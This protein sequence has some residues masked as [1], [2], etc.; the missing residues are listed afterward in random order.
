[1]SDVRRIIGG[2]DIIVSPHAACDLYFDDEY[3]DQIGAPTG[4]LSQYEICKVLSL[5]K[6]RPLYLSWEILDKCNFACPFCYIVGHSNNKIVRFSQIQPTLKRLI[7]K[8]LLFCTLTGGEATIHPDFEEIYTFLKMSGVV[9]EVYSN[10]HRISE[11]LISLFVK[12]PP[13]RLEIS[14]YGL[15]D[16]QFQNATARKLSSKSVLENIVK[17]RDAGIN[18]VCKTPINTL[19]EAEVRDISN[20]CRDHDVLYY[21]STDIFEAYDGTSKSEYAVSLLSAIKHEKENLTSMG[22]SLGRSG[23]F[24]RKSCFSCSVGSYGLHLDSSFSLL[25]CSAFENTDRKYEVLES[26]IDSALAKMDE[27]TAALIGQPIIGCEG[28]FASEICKMCPAKAEQVTN[29]DGI[30][31]S[32]KTTTEH[33]KTTQN[34]F[35]LLQ[36]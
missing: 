16:K 19:T 11:K 35:T 3:L 6:F 1:M 31:V 18:V 33:C 32:F 20:W 36:Q 13:Q 4:K 27:F 23:D 30:T 8:G 26:G 12:Y 22:E 24:G 34:K 2:V 5:D 29:S 28:C 7:E 21:T 17:L 9:T 25:P 10:G 14:V 15:S